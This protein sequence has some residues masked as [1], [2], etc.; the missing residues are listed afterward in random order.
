MKLNK[1]ISGI[2]VAFFLFYATL[3]SGWHPI[4]IDLDCSSKPV[5][6]KAGS[7][8][9]PCD[10]PNHHHEPH[11]CPLCQI[12][13]CL[14]IPSTSSQNFVSPTTVQHVLSFYYTNLLPV[15]VSLSSNVPRA[16]PLVFSLVV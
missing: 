16:P 1:V 9:T 14:G 12:I 13:K 5:I 2:V 6:N 4:S 3:G 8:T 10:N 15:L 7:P 11:N